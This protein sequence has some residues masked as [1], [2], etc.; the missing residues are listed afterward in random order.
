[1]TL[2]IA[3]TELVTIVVV[4]SIIRNIG[5]IV[6]SATVEIAVLNATSVVTVEVVMVLGAVVSL[7]Y[8]PRG[9]S[10]LF[11]KFLKIRLNVT[12]YFVTT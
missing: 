12:V 4:A 1:M 6:V 9:S 3:T 2:I 7:R 5:V 8:I 10:L 11:E